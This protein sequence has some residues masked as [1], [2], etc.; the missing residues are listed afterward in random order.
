[1]HR[2]YLYV[3][4]RKLG[5]RPHSHG[6]VLEPKWRGQRIEE[7]VFQRPQ[8]GYWTILRRRSKLVGISAGMLHVV[9]AGMFEA[10]NRAD[11]WSVA[12]AVMRE[13][14]EEVYGETEEQGDGEPSFDDHIWRKEPLQTL[15]RGIAEGSVELSFTG[16][17]CDLLNLRPEICTILFVREAGLT[18][19]R[20]MAMNWEYE[21][22]GPAGAFGTSW[23]NID[24]QSKQLKV[25]DIVPSGLACLVLG[26][27]WMRERHG[28]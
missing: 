26:R 25:G 22:Q 7:L 13:M 11:S 17:A 10:G 20:R 3:R 1:V 27:N 4:K 23:S 15:S 2:T 14:L 12:S 18:E 9:P 8:K 28:I 5:D 16:I 6:R 19:I 21:R 24:A